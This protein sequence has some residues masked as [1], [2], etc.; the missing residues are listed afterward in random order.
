MKHNTFSTNQSGTRKQLGLKI[1]IAFMLLICGVTLGLMLYFY[2]YKD[3]KAGLYLSFFPAIVGVV[4]IFH[5]P[6][7]R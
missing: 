5:W 1:Y 6:K 2:L 3:N 4:Y 7:R